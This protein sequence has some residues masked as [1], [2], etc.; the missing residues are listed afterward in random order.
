MFGNKQCIYADTDEFREEF[1][2]TGLMLIFIIIITLLLIFHY[3]S[4][5]SLITHSL[6]GEHFIDG[7]VILLSQDSQLP[8]LLLLQSLEHSLVVRL[9]R[10]LQQVVPEGFVLPGLSFASL[11]ELL[12]DLELLRLKKTK[13]TQMMSEGETEREGVLNS[14]V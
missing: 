14:I 9:R 7:V 3:L 11:L 1:K 4:E 6:C 13:Q 12:L 8:R 10:G 5:R 2:T